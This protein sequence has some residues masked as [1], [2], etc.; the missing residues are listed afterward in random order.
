[1]IVL[2]SGK[3]CEKLRKDIVL[4]RSLNWK[5]GIIYKYITCMI[6]HAHVLPSTVL[7]SI[8]PLS[9]TYQCVMFDQIT[10]N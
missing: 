10:P 9:F 8:T 2:A 6:R 4:C 1:M 7:F 5:D 3:L